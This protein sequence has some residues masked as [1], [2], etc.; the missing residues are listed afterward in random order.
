MYINIYKF[1]FDI[2]NRYHQISQVVTNNSIIRLFSERLTLFPFIIYSVLVASNKLEW[3]QLITQIN[4]K[5]TI[6]DAKL[7]DSMKY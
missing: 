4:R 6:G 1:F 3:T 5:S 2:Y 7:D